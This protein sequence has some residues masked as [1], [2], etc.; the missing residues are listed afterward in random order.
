MS[1]DATAER[2]EI[3]GKTFLTQ[4]G[5]ARELKVSIR[6]VRRWEAMRAAPPRIVIGR[7]IL[8]DPA[9][10][11]G[12]LLSNEQHPVRAGRGRKAA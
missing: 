1:D 3:A 2:I 6:T 12:W 11:H 8:Y 9:K 7:T 10:L 5:L 4:E